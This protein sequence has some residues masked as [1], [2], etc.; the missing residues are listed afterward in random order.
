MRKIGFLQERKEVFSEGFVVFGML[1][2]HGF[3]ESV[4]EVKAHLKPLTV[5]VVGRRFLPIH[6]LNKLVLFD[7]FGKGFPIDDF[8]GNCGI[9]VVF[10]FWEKLAAIGADTHLEVIL[11]YG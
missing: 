4:F 6:P 8:V 9:D 3:Y 11:P 2:S 10:A 1:R 5:I 7:Q